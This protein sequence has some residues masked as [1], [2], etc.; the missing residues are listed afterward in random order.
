MPASGTG[1][2]TPERTVTPSMG[3]VESEDG[4]VGESGPDCGSRP[5]DEDVFVMK[6]I[7]WTK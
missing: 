3:A 4:S 1:E 5:S 7:L 2:R 6:S